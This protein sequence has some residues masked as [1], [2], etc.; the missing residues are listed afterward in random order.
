MPTEHA[1]TPPSTVLVLGLHRLLLNFESCISN[2]EV[3]QTYKNAMFLHPCLLGP[4][5]RTPRALQF[6][7]ISWFYPE[8]SLGLCS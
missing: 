4:P 2:S 1:R 3:F 6:L 8:R 5:P 7:Q